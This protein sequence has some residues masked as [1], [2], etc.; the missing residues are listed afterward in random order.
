ML[1][2]L[3]CLNTIDSVDAIKDPDSVAWVATFL[4]GAGYTAFKTFL[5]P[6]SNQVLDVLIDFGHGN[7]ERFS[8]D[9]IFPD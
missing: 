2:G 8:A 3:R 5:T 4:D 7:V 9:R 6:T 1:I